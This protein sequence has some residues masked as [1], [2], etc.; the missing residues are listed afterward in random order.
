MTKPTPTSTPTTA[1]PPTIMRMVVREEPF[2]S[3]VGSVGFAVGARVGPSKGGG[4]GDG[5]L[6]SKLACIHVVN[7]MVAQNYFNAM[8]V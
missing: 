1:I 2:S 5:V 4:I 7:A 6:K 8:L 3:S